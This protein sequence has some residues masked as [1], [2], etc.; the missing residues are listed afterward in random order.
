MII[1]SAYGD[2]EYAR[3]ALR[4]NISNYLLKPIQIP[5]FISVINKA[6]AACK[7]KEAEKLE[8]DQLL[9]GY[10]RGLVYEKEKMLKEAISGVKH[11]ENK[12]NN[13]W[14]HL[15]LI[16]YGKKFFDIHADRFNLL[17]SE[18]I[19]YEFD[20][21]N[22]NEHQSVLLIQNHS[23]LEKEALRAVGEKIVNFSSESFSV[24]V[25]LVIGNPVNDLSLLYD[26]F[27]EM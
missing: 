19:G 5:E 11:L 9:E 6:I 27:N 15:I 25:G 17:L 1:Y 2:F 26:V 4:T 8:K 12:G 20:Y 3:R 21:L 16:D 10:N 13:L 7:I 23:L 14:T 24:N 18:Q 22:L